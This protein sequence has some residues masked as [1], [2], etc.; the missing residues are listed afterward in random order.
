MTNVDNQV[1]ELAALD[2]LHAAARTDVYKYVD[3]TV[4][5]LRTCPSTAVVAAGVRLAMTRGNWAATYAIAFA[6]IIIV[7]LAQKIIEEEK[8]G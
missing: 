7:D 8:R 2:Q 1:G 5:L 4:E 3:R 6:S